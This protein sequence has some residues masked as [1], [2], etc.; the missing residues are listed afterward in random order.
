MSRKYVLDGA[1]L[2]CTMG[3][4]QGKLTV[5]SQTK[6]H[7]QGKKIATDQDVQVAP[8]FGSCKTSSPPPPCV[9]DLQPW[10]KTGKKA[11]MGDKRFVMEDSMTHCSKGGVV[12]VK[13]HTQ[14]AG[15]GGPTQ[16]RQ[17]FETVPFTG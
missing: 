13:E 10:N 2:Q 16:V 4:T 11:A 9:P 1:C 3:S 17:L 5:T 8:T 15:G 6:L 7:A 14:K 12:T